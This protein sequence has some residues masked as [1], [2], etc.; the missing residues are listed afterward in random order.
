MFGKKKIKHF[1]LGKAEAE[2]EV[3]DPRFEAWYQ[4]PFNVE[5]RIIQDEIFIITGRKGSGKS[6]TANHLL[7]KSRSDQNLFVKIVDLQ[8]VERINSIASRTN[9][10]L[11]DRTLFKWLCLVELC[12]L[13]IA[14]DR[15]SFS[16]GVRKLKQFLATNSRIVDIAKFQVT[17]IVEEINKGAKAHVLKQGFSFLSKYIG[18]KQRAPIAEL[19][20]GLEEVVT[21]VLQY[22]DLKDLR[23]IIFIDDL[24]Y[25]LT[26]KSKGRI[27]LM[28]DMVSTIKTMRSS[29]LYGTKAFIVMLLRNDVKRLLTGDDRNLGKTFKSSSFNLNWFSDDSESIYETPLFLFIQE[30]LKTQNTADKSFLSQNDI[31]ESLFDSSRTD[32]FSEIRKLTSYRPRDFIL[33]F[34]KWE[35]QDVYIMQNEDEFQRL[36]K[37]YVKNYFEEL[38][39]EL[40]LS[41]PE[42]EEQVFKQ[43]IR[44]VYDY[45]KGGGVYISYQELVTQVEETIQE[46]SPHGL[47]KALI[48]YTVLTP[49]FYNREVIFQEDNP[50]D[51]F[52]VEGVGYSLH[53]AIYR[54][55]AINR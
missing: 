21:E 24:D 19:L 28:Q 54:Y 23:F 20:P 29:V 10:S 35:G 36:V 49:N 51:A 48:N 3:S 33:F 1:K 8:E 46:Y 45:C 43:F 16:N 9:E 34:K 53:P 17:D 22:E 40:S 25:K 7:H 41:F 32:V 11:E 27:S 14:S 42:L 39:D 4:D 38:I 15:A 26:A 37:D 13:I 31:L 12:K 18:N 52:N 44:L 30:R 5:E 2:A 55:F 47:I 6:M 50:S